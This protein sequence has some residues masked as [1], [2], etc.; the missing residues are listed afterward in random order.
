MQIEMIDPI[1][2]KPH[3]QN[4]KVHTDKQIDR[5]AKSMDNTGG[6]LQPI[7]TD[8]DMVILAGHGR[9][10]AHKKRGDVECPVFKKAGLTSAQKKKFLLADNQTNAMTGNAFD[11]VSALLIELDG[12]GVEIADIGFTEK[13]LDKFLNFEAEEDEADKFEEASETSEDMRELKESLE[14][15]AGDCVGDYQLPRLMLRVPSIEDTEFV[16]WMNRHRTPP[17]AQGQMHYHLFGRESTKGLDPQQTMMSFYIDDHRFERVYTK[18]RDNTQR[19]INAGLRYVTMPDFS[20]S[21]GAPLPYNMWNAYRSF[22]CALYWQLAGLDVIPNLVAWDVDSIEPCSVPIPENAPTV[23]CQIQTMGRRL[24]FSGDGMSGWDEDQY[25]TI[26]GAQLDIIKP[27]AM[28]VYGGEP[29]LILGEEICKRH[30]VRF[31]G[32]TNRALA[33]TDLNTERGF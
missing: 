14:L 24:R 33:A 11:A 4:A 5:I 17:L 12:E 32:V 22:Y 18:L 2:L 28:I 29:G 13:E 31:I 6:S 20:L 30:S 19:F 9:W 15:V 25:R 26:I 10:M 7:V 23:S 21:T 1:L 16:V 8:E 27:E 3:P